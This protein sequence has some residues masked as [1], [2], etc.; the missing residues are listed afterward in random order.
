MS[1]F[2]FWHGS[3]WERVGELRLG[4]VHELNLMVEVLD[5]E[6]AFESDRTWRSQSDPLRLAL[7]GDHH[8]GQTKT[9]LQNL[10]DA[11][12]AQVNEVRGLAMG[13][14]FNSR[15]FDDY[16]TEAEPLVSPTLDFYFPRNEASCDIERV[17]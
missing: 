5:P 2:P 16:D 13:L 14:T 12:S 10:E 9:E 17:G 6:T 7:R 11:R 1:S 3:S 8:G 15:E 4:D